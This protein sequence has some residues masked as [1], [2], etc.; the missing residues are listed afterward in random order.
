MLILLEGNNTTV[1]EYIETKI[2]QTQPSPPSIK[3]IQNIEEAMSFI[4]SHV[5]SIPINRIFVSEI[6]KMIVNKLEPPPQGEGDK[7][8]GEYRNRNVEISKSMHIPPDTSTVSQYMDELFD[9]IKQNDS[10]KHDLLKIAIAHHRFVWIHP[11]TNGNGQT[12]RLFTY[13]ILDYL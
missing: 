9:F 5:G 3:E 6:H 2:D 7:T 13:A 8:P 1:A 11:F 4:E 10:A 12:V